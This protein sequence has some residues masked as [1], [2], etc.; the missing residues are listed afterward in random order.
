MNDRAVIDQQQIAAVREARARV[1]PIERI[2]VPVGAVRLLIHVLAE[3]HGDLA[4]AAALLRRRGL[5]KDEQRME[6]LA[7]LID[8]AARVRPADP[9]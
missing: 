3:T 8:D 6:L 4:E 2:P 1:V 9:A 5:L 7:N